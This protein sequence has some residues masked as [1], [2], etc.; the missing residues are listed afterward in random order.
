MS[1]ELRVTDNKLN[2]ALITALLSISCAL[3]PIVNAQEQTDWW[4]D[5]EVL[6]FKHNNAT[7]SVTEKFDSR[8][9]KPFAQRIDNVFS[10]FHFIDPSWLQQALPVCDADNLYTQSIRLDCYFTPDIPTLLSRNPLADRY[11]M[12]NQLP[13]HY[14]GYE[15]F[16]SEQAH[17]LPQALLQLTALYKEIKWDK[18]YQP[19]LH[20]V[21]R[22]PVYVGQENAYSIPILAGENLTF[23]P[24]HNLSNH[25]PNEWTQ[26]PET[27]G[28]TDAF[29]ND[30]PNSHSYMPILPLIDATLAAG[31]SD[32]D[33]RSMPMPVYPDQ[34]KS[35]QEQ[36]IIDTDAVF[37]LEGLLTVFIKYINKVPYLHIESHALFYTEAL[38]DD[39]MVIKPHTFEQRRRIISNQVHYFDHPYF[40]MIVE[41]RRHKR[42]APEPIE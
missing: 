5:V 24:A 19:L 37:E 26:A 38:E 40:G 21:W 17:I 9:D 23:T 16:R 6:I 33:N 34:I 29:S 36:T 2:K 22:Q 12:L 11:Q 18:S 7:K 3:T 20:T 15:P 28:S 13:I 42:P 31:M 4:F 39:V 30:I 32:T 25:N 14:D 35:I 27:L 1:S 10:T 41:L 8:V